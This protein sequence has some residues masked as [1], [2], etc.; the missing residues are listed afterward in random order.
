MKILIKAN[1]Y[2]INFEI[3]S[4]Y[5]ITK[6]PVHKNS[7]SRGGS[8]AWPVPSLSP[9]PLGGCPPVDQA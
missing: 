8:S 2:Q 3:L 9:G 4:T 5:S 7:C 1:S 6:G